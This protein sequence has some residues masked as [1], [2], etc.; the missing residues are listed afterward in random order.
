MVKDSAATCN[1]VF[2][3]AIVVA[4]GYFG[5]VGSCWGRSSGMCC[6]AIIVVG[7]P[8]HNSFRPSKN[9]QGSHNPQTKQNKSNH[10]QPKDS[11][12]N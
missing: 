11:H 8:T 2:F 4:S 10:V 1:A 3:P 5:Y 7:L 12:I 6:S 9:I